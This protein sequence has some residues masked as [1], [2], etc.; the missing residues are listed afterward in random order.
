MSETTSTDLLY[1]LHPVLEALRAKD[2]GL[3]RIYLEQGRRGRVV[4]EILGL[5]KA[6]HVPVAFEA[7]EGLDRRA[8]TARHQG[9][10]GVAAAKAYLS[11]D[12]LLE[13]ISGLD[14]PLL[15]VLDGIEDPHNLGAILRT[16]EAAG[17]QGVILPTRRAVGLTATVAKVSA[18]AVEHLSVARV[19][20][21]AQAIERLKEARFWIY[22]LDAK[23][24]RGYAEVD[25]RGPVALVVG[26]EGRGLRPLVAGRC[27]GTVRIPM[28]GKVESLNVSVATA[29]VLYE[30]LRQRAGTNALTRAVP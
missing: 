22:G 5:A 3:H 10:V 18:G 26:G 19:V 30:I 14:A 23:G 6:R 17:A 29:I 28:R 27:D 13:S 4:D 11:L 25:Y 20:N 16:A 21:L 12:D 24:T 15:L 2:C 8:G 1:G 9:A 7:R